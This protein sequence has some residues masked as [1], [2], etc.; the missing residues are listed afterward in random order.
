MSMQCALQHVCF[1]AKQWTSAPGEQPMTSDKDGAYLRPPQILAEVLRALLT[2]RQ[3]LGSQ[4]LTL[5][6]DI[7]PPHASTY[8]CQVLLRLCIAFRQH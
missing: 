5:S 1:L 8:I 4:L 3:R 6:I 7:A 2:L